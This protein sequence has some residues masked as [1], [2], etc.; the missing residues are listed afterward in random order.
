MA[1]K[2]ESRIVIVREYRASVDELWD[3]WTT[4]DGFEA[5]WG[6][7]GFRAD[8]HAMEPRTGGAVHY[9][10]VAASPEAVAAMKAAGEPL[11]TPCRGYFAEFAVGRRLVLKQTIDF[12][13]GVEPYE[14][15]IEV[16]FVALPGGMARMTVTL[17][18][19]HDVQTTAMQHQGFL[20]QLSKLDRRYDHAG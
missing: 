7:E 10:M 11:S 20:S 1:D 8:V 3:L 14:S 12:L 15:T 2:A 6:P 19:M 17:H 16:D 18:Q 4:R 5:W 13:P 9:D